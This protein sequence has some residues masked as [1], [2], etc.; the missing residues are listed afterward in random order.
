MY[1]K[2]TTAPLVKIT[3]LTEEELIAALVQSKHD[4]LFQIDNLSDR[5]FE[6][7]CEKYDNNITIKTFLIFESLSLRATQEMLTPEVLLEITE[8]PTLWLKVEESQQIFFHIIFKASLENLEKSRFVEIAYEKNPLVIDKYFEALMLYYPEI[9]CKEEHR[10]KILCLINMP[11]SNPVIKTKTL[12][13]MAE[14]V[15]G[16]KDA[17]ALNT[18]IRKVFLRTITDLEKANQCEAV[19]NA[20]INEKNWQGAL[21]LCFGLLKI[22]KLELA[23][24]LAAQIPKIKISPPV[25]ASALIDLL[26]PTAENGETENHLWAIFYGY[27]FETAPTIRDLD[28]ETRIIIDDANFKN[29]VTTALD[30]NDQLPKMK[31]Q[32]LEFLHALEEE[33]SIQALNA[34]EKRYVQ[35]IK[36]GEDLIEGSNMRKCLENL[37]PYQKIIAAYFK[38]DIN[39]QMAFEKIL[40]NTLYFK[41]LSSEKTEESI[42]KWKVIISHELDF[43]DFGKEQASFLLWFYFYSFDNLI[44]NTLSDELAFATI[45]RIMLLYATLM[46]SHPDNTAEFKEQTQQKMEALSHWVKMKRENSV[47]AQNIVSNYNMLYDIISNY[48]DLSSIEKIEELSSLQFNRNQWLHQIRTSPYRNSTWHELLALGKMLSHEF[49]DN[50]IILDYMI[51]EFFFKLKQYE[52]YYNLYGLS[53]ELFSVLIN[54]SQYAKTTSIHKIKLLMAPLLIPFDSFSTETLSALPYQQWVEE[55]SKNPEQQ[56]LFFSEYTEY[57]RVILAENNMFRLEK[58]QANLFLAFAYALFSKNEVLAEQ[59]FKTLFAEPPLTPDGVV[60][61]YSINASI[62]QTLSESPEFSTAGVSLQNTLKVTFT[63][64]SGKPIDTVSSLDIE[65]SHCKMIHPIYQKMFL[66]KI[67]LVVTD[68]LSKKECSHDLGEILSLYIQKGAFFDQNTPF[69][70]GVIFSPFALGVGEYN[71]YIKSLIHLI[72]LKEDNPKEN[73]LLMVSDIQTIAKLITH[74][75]RNLRRIDITQHIVKLLMTPSASMKA[76]LIPHLEENLAEEIERNWPGFQGSLF[77]IK[78]CFK[79]TRFPVKSPSDS[80][81]LETAKLCDTL[82]SAA[83]ENN[84]ALYD[85]TLIRL[86]RITSQRGSLLVLVQGTFLDHLPFSTLH[87]Y[88]EDE[89]FKQRTLDLV[90]EITAVSSSI[91]VKESERVKKIHQEQFAQVRKSLAAVLAYFNQ[92]ISDIDTASFKRSTNNELKALVNQ[93]SHFENLFLIREESEFKKQISSKDTEF[94]KA[95]LKLLSKIDTNLFPLHAAELQNEY[96]LTFEGYRLSIFNLM[97]DNLWEP[98]AIKNYPIFASLVDSLQAPKQ[99][100]ASSHIEEESEFQEIESNPEVPKPVTFTQILAKTP[101]GN[102]S[103]KWK[104]IEK[105]GTFQLALLTPENLDFLKWLYQNQLQD[106]ELKLWSSSTSMIDGL[107]VFIKDIVEKI[108]EFDPNNTECDAYANA[109]LQRIKEQAHDISRIYLYNT[110]RSSFLRFLPRISVESIAYPNIETLDSEQ[111]TQAFSVIPRILYHPISHTTIRVLVEKHHDSTIMKHL[112]KE[113]NQDLLRQIID[114]GIIMPHTIELILLFLEKGPSIYPNEF[115]AL[116]EHAITFLYHDEF[117]DIQ[118]SRLISVIEQHYRLL[119]TDTASIEASPNFDQ[120]KTQMHLL[121]GMYKLFSIVYISQKHNLAQFIFEHFNQLR[122]NRYADFTLDLTTCDHLVGYEDLPHSQKNT[123]M[124]TDAFVTQFVTFSKIDFDIDENDVKIIKAAYLDVSYRAIIDTANIYSRNTSEQRIVESSLGKIRTVMMALQKNRDLL[125]IA[126][127][128]PLT[129][130]LREVAENVKRIQSTNYVSTFE[131]YALKR[132][133]F[134][135]LEQLVKWREFP[136]LELS[137]ECL[138]KLLSDWIDSRDHFAY[139]FMIDYAALCKHRDISKDNLEAN[140]HDLSSNFA[141]L[142]SSISESFTMYTSQWFLNKTDKNHLIAQGL[143]FRVLLDAAE[144]ND[145]HAYT[146]GLSNATQMGCGSKYATA[147]RVLPSIEIFQIYWKS[148]FIHDISEILK[149][150]QSVVDEYQTQTAQAA[151]ASAASSAAVVST[152][153]SSATTNATSA[154]IDAATKAPATSLYQRLGTKL[155]SA[156]SRANNQAEVVIQVPCANVGEADQEDQGDALRYPG[157]F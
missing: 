96:K 55:I 116:M 71:V 103:E 118:L 98:E 29:L 100:D 51:P 36:D 53:T 141:L 156:I 91:L 4:I 52:D 130:I 41:T 20:F 50:D 58:L 37:K 44:E 59:I 99:S 124:I 117:S 42:G 39:I 93:W 46:R 70:E 155:S 95:Y 16:N 137:D 49:S 101:G 22:G 97:R 18:M 139:Y 133:R 148:V 132:K 157:G 33:L 9:S 76:S 109:F 142:V 8:N 88:L 35:C 138:V 151:A 14:T 72:H 154:S 121:R 83:R 85:A 40:N 110:L 94:P 67:K 34:E 7:L 73:S 26:K 6:A 45:F 28:I 125:Q 69:K 147:I 68:I 104:I 31:N 129:R 79:Q 32:I 10:D 105:S 57:R 54:A 153:T 134:S 23:N 56:K 1:T 120:F 48:I 126:Q 89:K 25:T 144:K 136:N 60:K 107:V 77:E 102:F 81:L 92:S 63:Y 65:D 149:L 114:D 74:E 3:D 38:Q 87:F 82:F 127:T 2:K 19:Y 80:E 115:I 24:R 12:R 27:F 15:I 131:Q 75:R 122:L 84:V 11:F 30:E 128:I 64:F 135:H 119:Q 123:L 86:Y 43:R 111:L 152:D 47:F 21:E 13:K 62:F 78:N 17:G 146:F 108:S 90:N 106:L 145:A 5:E 112:L 61:R 143:H 140:F 150:S 66:D 113:F